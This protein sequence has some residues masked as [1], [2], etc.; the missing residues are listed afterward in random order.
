[1]GRE[2]DNRSGLEKVRESQ[3]EIERAKQID[4]LSRLNQQQQY[5]RILRQQESNMSR[6]LKALRR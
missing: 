6:G 4:Q 1:V 3:R 5:G 2:Y